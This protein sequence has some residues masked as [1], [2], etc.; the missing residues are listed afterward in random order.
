MPLGVAFF[1]PKKKGNQMHN[2]KKGPAITQKQ[3][4]VLNCLSFEKFGEMLEYVFETKIHEEYAK[5]KFEKNKHNMADY[6]ME[7]DPDNFKRIVQFLQKEHEQQLA[8]RLPNS[9][10]LLLKIKK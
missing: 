4:R 1:L 8:A 5:D 3:M 7:I 9:T 2:E 10:Q 6:L